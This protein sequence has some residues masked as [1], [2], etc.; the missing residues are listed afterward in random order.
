[1]L[2]CASYT[3]KSSSLL[4]V[5]PIHLSNKQNPILGER[6]VFHS[7]VDNS[8]S[9]SSL[10]FREPD[11][12]L[13]SKTKLWEQLCPDLSTSINQYIQWRDWRLGSICGNKWIIVS[14]DVP[15][16]STVR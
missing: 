15:P 9:S 1:M 13:S 12:L 2:L 11:K 3:E 16:G 6:F 8:K 5:Q 10:S 4:K 14:D 7:L